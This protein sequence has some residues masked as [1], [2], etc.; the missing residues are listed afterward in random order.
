MG[1]CRRCIAANKGVSTHY[2]GI[3]SAIISLTQTNERL[4]M[5]TDLNLEKMKLELIS[6]L[7]RGR[8][9]AARQQQAGFDMLSKQLFSLVEEGQLVAQ[10]QTILQ[11]LLFEEMEQR[12]EAI[13]D[14]HKTTLDWMFERNETKFMNWLE[15]GNGI[16]WVKGK[17]YDPRSTPLINLFQIW[18]NTPLIN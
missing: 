2:S 1:A 11:T 6:T 7:D 14:A 5:N 17:V 13:K 16:Y 12:E 4:K 3:T 10:Q 18:K 9:E 8:G 15:T